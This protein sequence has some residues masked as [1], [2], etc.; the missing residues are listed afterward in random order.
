MNKNINDAFTHKRLFYNHVDYQIKIVIA[1][2]LNWKKK[3]S[4]ILTYDSKVLN[5]N[6]LLKDER[7][8]SLISEKSIII[9]IINNKIFLYI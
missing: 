6:I 9:Y 1:M 7:I 4:N 8:I 5:K 2:N 3:S